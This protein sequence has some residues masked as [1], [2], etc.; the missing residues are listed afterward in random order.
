MGDS[1][2]IR[3]LAREL[4][5]SADDDQARLLRGSL[6]DPRLREWTYL[7]GDRDGLPYGDLD[8]IQRELVLELLDA[9][10]TDAG[11][12]TVAV[13]I[14]AERVR[15]RIGSGNLEMDSDIGPDRYWVR[16]LG[17]PTGGPSGEEPWGWRI[18]GHHLAVHLMMAAD[19]VSVT[20]HFVGAE[21]AEVRVG[22]QAGL[23]ALGPEE[24]LARELLHALD[25]DQRRIA[26]YD[27]EPPKDILTRSD[28]VADPAVL[29][30]GLSYADLT[31]PQRNLLER[32]V[33][34]YLDRAPASYADACWR[35][36]EGAGVDEL[37][38]AWAGGPNRGERHYY[39]VTGPELLIE[40]DNTQ[41]DGN[42]AHSVWRHLRDDWGAD[43]LRAHYE[44]GHQ[45]G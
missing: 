28:P 12:A 30:D 23:R 14:E 5:A 42:H 40:Y 43:L 35:E 10:H 36:V 27:D 25:P 11:A 38:F 24:D 20:P 2:R 32:L 31:D 26:V 33:R 34:R 17:D 6:D 37:A 44:A 16:V 21:P 18:N 29:P 8:V 45:A 3:D 41:D 13:A 7:P 9:T 39:C 1:K 22:P 4:V 19:R 15:R